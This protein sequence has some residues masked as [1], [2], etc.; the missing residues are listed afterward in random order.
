LAADS[1]LANV[2]TPSKLRKLMRPFPG[3]QVANS[4]AVW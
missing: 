3:D 1:A 4:N 2:T